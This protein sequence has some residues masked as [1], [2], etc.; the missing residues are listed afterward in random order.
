M[1]FA[2]W[3]PPPHLPKRFD[4]HFFL[5]PAPRHQVAAAD[6]REVV[7]AAWLR[8][9]TV[10]AAAEAAELNLM[11]ATYMNLRWLAQFTA[12]G[13]ALAAAQARTVVTVISEPIDSTNG[14]VFRIPDAAGYGETDILEH[15]LRR[16]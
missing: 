14:R 15:R 16:N 4:T 3:I 1:P 12:V 8:P 7:S 13:V 9:R 2:H 10:V 11:F 6:L 5:A